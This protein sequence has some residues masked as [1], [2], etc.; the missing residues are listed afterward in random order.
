MRLIIC[1]TPADR[2]RIDEAIAGAKEMKVDALIFLPYEENNLNTNILAQDLNKHIG[3]DTDIIF[4]HNQHQTHQDHRAVSSAA[5]TLARKVPNFLMWETVAPSEI[6][7][8]TFNPQFFIFGDIDTKIKALK[9]HKSQVKKYSSAWVDAV[10]GLA[11]LRS[12]QFDMYNSNRYAE[13]FEVV[14]LRG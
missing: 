3:P 11:K 9:K 6:A 12:V 10:K 5:L 8:T 13:A 7:L 4:T 14:K 2:N 1:T